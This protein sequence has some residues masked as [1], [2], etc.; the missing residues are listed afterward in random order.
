[1][2]KGSPGYRI[3]QAKRKRIGSEGEIDSTKSYLRTLEQVY[4]KKGL[5]PAVS[6]EIESTLYSIK[7]RLANLFER[8]KDYRDSRMAQ[9]KNFIVRGNRL[10]RITTAIMTIIGLFF[11]VLFLSSDL[12]GS[13]IGFKYGIKPIGAIYI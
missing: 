3:R 9:R 11:G 7:S 5:F 2:Y 4:N 1:M 6:Y 10:E 13:I 12:S 8:N